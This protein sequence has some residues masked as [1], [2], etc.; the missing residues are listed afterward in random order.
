MPDA[1]AGPSPNVKQNAC[2][3]AAG[4][5]SA[6]RLRAIVPGRRISWSVSGA[7]APRL[8]IDVAPV[9][10]RWRCAVESDLE[11]DRVTRC[12]RA[13]DEVHIPRVEAERDPSSR[14]VEH[15]ALRRRSTRPT[16]PRCSQ[17]HLVSA[18]GVRELP[19]PSSS[20][21]EAAAARIPEVRLGRRERAPVG[22]DLEP[23]RVDRHEAAR[24]ILRLRA[25]AAGST[26][27]MRRTRLRRRRGG[28]SGPARRRGRGPAN[29]GWRSRPTPRSRC[30]RPRGSGYRDHACVAHIAHVLLERDSGVWTPTIVSPARA[31]FSCSRA[32]EAAAS[33]AS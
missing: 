6:R 9:R 5:R 13:E 7:S 23:R 16:D 3:P 14:F 20:E 24:R 30:R 32:Q 29:S 1:L 10:D 28:G 4:S 31:Y 22:G 2:A 25:G 21:R 11:R 33:A 15:D 8:R 26:C 18:V 17:R 19:Q 12:R 27:S